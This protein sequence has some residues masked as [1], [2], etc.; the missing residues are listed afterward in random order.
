MRL[1][2]T[3]S[4]AESD[5]DPL[6]FDRFSKLQ[7]LSRS[8][9]ESLHDLSTI[10]LSL[11]NFVGE[12]ESVLQQQ[13]RINT[14]LQEGLMRTRMIK[15]STQAPRLRHILRQTARELGKRAELQLG[16]SEVEIDRTVMERMIG[17]FE[18]MIRNALDH[19]IETE[20]ERRQTAVRPHHD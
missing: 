6:E 17:P 9:S 7:Q 11:G 10:Q 4:G 8:L 3:T 14:D 18:H 12:A 13:A 1:R 20:H 19:G 2:E 16:G 5:F 15:F